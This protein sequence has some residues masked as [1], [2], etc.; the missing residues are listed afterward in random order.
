MDKEIEEHLDRAQQAIIRAEASRNLRHSAEPTGE[1]DCKIADCWMF[2]A[3]AKTQIQIHDM[4]KASQDFQP[5][6]GG[7]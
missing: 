2:L 5:M 3:Q 1:L 4:M 7:Y 6:E